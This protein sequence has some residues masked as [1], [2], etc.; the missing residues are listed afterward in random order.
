MLLIADVPIDVVPIQ[1]GIITILV[2][3]PSQLTATDALKI[4]VRRVIPTANETECHRLMFR[5]Q[6][7]ALGGNRSVVCGTITAA[8][9]T[10]LGTLGYTVTKNS[11]T[12]ST[13]SW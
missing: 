5:I 4:A 9:L 7:A 11:P 13:I 10:L 1:V 3:D 12:S 8:G 2:T 6:H